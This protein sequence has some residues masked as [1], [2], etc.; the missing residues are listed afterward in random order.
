MKQRITLSLPAVQQSWLK[1]RAADLGISVSE[2]LRRVID[3]LRVPK[4]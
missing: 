1:Q 2:F 4:G 3:E